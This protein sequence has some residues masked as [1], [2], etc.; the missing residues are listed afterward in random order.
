MYRAILG[1]EIHLILSF[2]EDSNHVIMLGMDAILIVTVSLVLSVVIVLYIALVLKFVM[3][4]AKEKNIPDDPQ[5]SFIE[6]M[7]G[8][9]PF[10]VANTKCVPIQPRTYDEL[11]GVTELQACFNEC[12]AGIRLDF[13]RS[14]VSFLPEKRQVRGSSGELLGRSSGEEHGLLSRKA[15]GNRAKAGLCEQISCEERDPEARLR[16]NY[17][18]ILCY[19]KFNFLPSFLKF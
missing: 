10:R 1:A 2:Q 3:R 16:C 5:S 9:H 4:K 8:W 17:L 15:A 12:A 11:K 19:L 7:S 14:L 18:I 13:R 6:R